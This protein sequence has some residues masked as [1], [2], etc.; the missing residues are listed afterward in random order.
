[1]NIK[2]TNTTNLNLMNF[3]EMFINTYKNIH[4]KKNV[5]YSLKLLKKINSL[6][7]EEMVIEIKKVVLD[8]AIANNTKNHYIANV[9]I[10]LKWYS[11]LTKQYFNPKEFE[12]LPQDLNKKQP[13][14][15]KEMEMLESELNFFGKPKFTLAWKLL[16]YNGLRLSEFINLDWRQLRLNNYQM[17]IR[18]AKNNNNRLFMIP[19]EL[20][21]EFEQYGIEWNYNNLQDN[22]QKFRH[23]IYFRHPEFT[24]PIHAHM[25]RHYFVTKAAINLGSIN[26]VQALTGHINPDVLMTTYIKYNNFYQKIWLEQANA[27]TLEA[28]DKQKLLSYIKISNHQISYL[29][30]KLADYGIDYELPAENSPNLQELN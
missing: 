3:F 8:L 27:E 18:T 7:I 15:E 4:T 10:F 29:K 14:T 6:K 24:K 17:Q 9:K 16:K 19:P 11:N 26:K 5:K 13:Y 2:E 25:L 28:L 30:Q 12:L 1:M 22:F 23:F 20:I 21:G